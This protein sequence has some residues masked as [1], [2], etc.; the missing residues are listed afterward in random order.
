MNWESPHFRNSRINR[1][2]N[3]GS[4]QG[5]GVCCSPFDQ[6]SSS[7]APSAFL[8]ELEQLA[9]LTAGRPGLRLVVGEPGSGW[10]LNW[11]THTISID[12]GRL[13]SETADFTR[14]LV[15][16]ES[17]H[18]AI[19]RLSEMVPQSI[20]NDWRLHALLNLL[21]DC[22]IETWMQIRFPGCAAWVREYNDCLFRPLLMDKKSVPAA[23]QFLKGIASRWWFRK[24]AEPMDD[25]VRRALDAVWPAF[26]E[27][28]RALPPRPVRSETSPE[29]TPRTRLPSA[30]PRVT[31]RIHRSPTSKGCASHNTRCGPLFIAIS[32]RSFRISCHPAP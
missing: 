17:A 30:M 19:T 11:R 9:R 28:L 22:R 16:H 10:S 8:N 24:E 14:G 6:D 1:G 23:P 32:S 4:T 3:A 2:P 31:T 5:T 12:G 29:S 27:M 20:L 7:S 25:E 13:E 26:E 15:L 18:A 21:E